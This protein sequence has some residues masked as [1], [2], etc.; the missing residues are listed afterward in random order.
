MMIFSEDTEIARLILDMIASYS[1]SLLEE[2]KSKRMVCSII[3]PFRAFSCSPSLAPVYR[4][5]PSTLRVHQS[6]FS[7]FVSC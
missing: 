1:T 7:D 5:V 2:G 4:E 3:S 6:E